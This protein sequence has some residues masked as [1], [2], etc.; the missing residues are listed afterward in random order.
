M[1]QP[2]E[3]ALVS[4]GRPTVSSNEPRLSIVTG[5]KEKHG[6]SS[7]CWG[8]TESSGKMTWGDLVFWITG[9][10]SVCGSVLKPS[11]MWLNYSTQVEDDNNQ[12]YMSDKN[13]SSLT[14]RCYLQVVGQIV[15]L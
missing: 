1:K 13:K 14:G 4:S 10:V 5:I 11:I 9:A 3:V 8:A 15:L 7:G 6:I 2:N 12:E